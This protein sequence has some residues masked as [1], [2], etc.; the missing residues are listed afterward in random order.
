MGVYFGGGDGFVP[1][2]VLHEPDVRAPVDEMGGEGV[3]E[4]VGGHSFGE[5][6]LVDQFLDDI[7]YPNPGQ[8][9]PRA[10]EEYEVLVFFYLGDAG[11]VALDVGLQGFVGVSSKQDKAFLVP[12]AVYLDV[13]VLKIKVVEFHVDEL[14]YPNSAGV[15]G[16]DDGPVALPVLRVLAGRVDDGDDFLDA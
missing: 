16:L 9:L 4:G 5:A 7:V 6:D 14:R 15:E 8:G 13:V 12:F 2:H 3:T 10:A 11:T 1:E